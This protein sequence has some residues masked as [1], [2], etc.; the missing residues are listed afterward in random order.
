VQAGNDR[1]ILQDVAKGFVDGDLPG[2]PANRNA[3]DA[4][5]ADL[6]GDV[7]V[8]DQGRL[9]R[10]QEPRRSELMGLTRAER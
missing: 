4:N 9:L 2:R 8:V 5:L 7:I 6:G 10:A 3:P 1:E